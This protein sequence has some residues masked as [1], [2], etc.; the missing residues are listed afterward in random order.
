MRSSLAR[1]GSLTESVGQL[2]I[3]YRELLLPATFNEKARL[4]SDALH[5]WPRNGMM[6]IALPNVDGSFTFTLFSPAE[7]SASWKPSTLKSA[8]GADAFFRAT[9]PDLAAAAPEAGASLASAYVGRIPLVSCSPWNAGQAVVIGDAAHAI[10][11]FFGQ[12]LNAGLED[13]VLLDEMLD[14]VGTDVDWAGVFQR[15]GASRAPDTAA[16]A[17]L[18]LEN[19]DEMSRAVTDPAFLLRKNVEAEIQR[20]YPGLYLSRY[21]L[22]SFSRLA[23]RSVVEIGQ[24]QRELLDEVCENVRDPSEV[25]YARAAA[26]I[27]ERLAHRF[28]TLDSNPQFSS[29]PPQLRASA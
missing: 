5:I 13:C 9:F 11:P 14:D 10:T 28:P 27:S 1:R 25:D 7:E 6:L 18:S 24:L 3:E 21:E 8:E 16:I 19:L 29:E 12:G 2:N 20:R 4:A 17:A 26:L 23:Y 22:V 15:F